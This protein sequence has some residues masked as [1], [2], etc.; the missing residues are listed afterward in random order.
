LDFRTRLEE[1]SGEQEGLPPLF[2]PEG[3]RGNIGTLDPD[4]RIFTGA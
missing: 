1:E 4:A 3:T 2:V